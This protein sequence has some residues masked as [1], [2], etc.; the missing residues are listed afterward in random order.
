MKKVFLVGLVMLAAQVIMPVSGLTEEKVTLTI[1]MNGF[2][3]DNGTARVALYNTENG[4]NG[5][6]A[7]FRSATVKIQDKK[8]VC[9]IKDV[10]SGT[11]T[12]KA[13]HD[14]NDNDKLDKNFVG[15][16]KEAYG[17]SN[18]AKSKMGPGKYNEAKFVVAGNKTLNIKVD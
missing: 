2:P 12:I 9:E 16:P 4:F 10:P 1:N 6:E 15:F 14:A 3:N 7:A 17:V 18:N 11:Y 8:A 13:Y 5:K